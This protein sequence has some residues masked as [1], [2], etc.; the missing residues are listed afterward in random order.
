MNVITCVANHSPLSWVPFLSPFYRSSNTKMLSLAQGHRAPEEEGGKTVLWAT[1]ETLSQNPR[2]FATA[3]SA[4]LCLRWR[5]PLPPVLWSLP[6]CVSGKDLKGRA[7][8]WPQHE[9]VFVCSPQFSSVLLTMSLP[10]LWGVT[11]Q[12][13]SSWS[14]LPLWEL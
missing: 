6:L 5:P 13:R 1:S 8:A 2:P 14:S 4:L 7:M 9:P 3:L 10:L 12:F 11:W